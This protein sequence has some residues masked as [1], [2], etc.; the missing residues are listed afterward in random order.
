MSDVRLFNR[1]SHLAA[2]KVIQSYSTSFGAASRLLAEPVRGRIRDIYAM[3]RIADE[4][5]DG[6]AAEAGLDPEQIREMLD[7]FETDIFATIES[8]FS[9]NIVI[10]AFA[11]TTRTCELKAEHIRAFFRSMRADITQSVYRDDELEQ[12]IYGSAAVVGAMCLDVFIA[13]AELPGSGAAQKLHLKALQDGALHLGAAFQKINFLRDLAE[14]RTELGRDYLGVITETQKNAAIADIR[15]DLAVAR[16]AIPGLPRSSR[17]GVATAYLLF[18]A[19]TIK[20]A[21]VPASKL[22]QQRV[23]IPNLRKFALVIQAL[24]TARMHRLEV[25]LPASE[26]PQAYSGLPTSKDPK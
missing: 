5:V 20:L 17:L 3:V 24:F 1:M 8:G 23:R 26:D 13:E 15:A 9:P 14:D 6:P 2:A 16:A 12:Y 7:Q 25:L 18:N 19:L 21:A 11:R 22:Q 4:I 10:H